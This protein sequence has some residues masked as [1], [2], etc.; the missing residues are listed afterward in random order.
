MNYRFQMKT[1]HL[2][3]II[4]LVVFLLN[5]GCSTVISESPSTDSDISSISNASI[6]TE[7]GTST[8]NLVFANIKA[9]FWW[10]NESAASGMDGDRP[11]PKTKYLELEK[12]E[13]DGE[14]LTTYP[15]EVDVTSELQNNS[16]TDF[17]GSVRIHISA[18]F[19]D[20]ETRS[21]EGSGLTCENRPWINERVLLYESVK[22]KS[23]S[24]KKSVVK[25][26][27]L[28]KLL[29]EKDDGRAICAMRFSTQVIDRSGKIL[30][31][32]EK[33]VPVLLGD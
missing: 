17:E 12:W 5:W 20:Y 29:N 26:Y 15:H 8:P 21:F 30:N 31:S 16:V 6:S 9:S 3:L 2:L 4:G 28:T 14:G 27:D 22:I 7:M 25:D 18:R 32:K 33:V 10:W 1:V 13:Y 19:E 11:P 23:K 24:F